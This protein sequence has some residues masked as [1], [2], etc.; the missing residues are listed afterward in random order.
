[1]NILMVTAFTYVREAC[2]CL[3]F[4]GVCYLYVFDVISSY[5]MLDIYCHVLW[6]SAQ[7]FYQ[8]LSNKSIDWYIIL[9]DSDST[10]HWSWI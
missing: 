3:L 1:M 4:N 9:R 8:L 2:F 10:Y 7:S 6:Y 5:E